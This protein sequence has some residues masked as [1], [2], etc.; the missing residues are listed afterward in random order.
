M[1]KRLHVNQH[2]LRARQPDPLTIRTYNEVRYAKKAAING[3]SELVYRPD[4][5]LSCGAR[6]WMETTASI[7]IESADGQITRLD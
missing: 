7:D 3:P 6:L 2:R 1:L 4:K 5:P